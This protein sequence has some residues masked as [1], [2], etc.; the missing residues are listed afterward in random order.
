VLKSRFGKRN[1]EYDFR[2]TPY[3]LLAVK[4]GTQQAV[5][6]A[7]FRGTIASPD[8]SIPWLTETFNYEISGGLEPG[9]TAEWL[10]APNQFGKWGNV[11]APEDAVFTVETIRLD[12]A[13]GDALFDSGSFDDEDAKRLANLQEKY[14]N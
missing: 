9:E 14:G 1:G 2:A 11:D 7:Y 5:S 10:L 12:G 3:I 8:R 13:K 6:R 4:N